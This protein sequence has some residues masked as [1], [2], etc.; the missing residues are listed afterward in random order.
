MDVSNNSC[1][2]CSV[3]CEALTFDLGPLRKLSGTMC[4]HCKV[5]NGCSVYETRWEVCRTYFCG[6]RHL[7]LGEEW[8][9]D[10]AQ[11]LIAF[12]DGLAPDGLSGGIEFT[13]L[14]SHETLLWLPLVKFIAALME[15]PSPVYLSLPGAVGYQSPW[16]YL[17]NIPALQDGI[18]RRDLATTHAALTA[19]LQVCLDYPKTKIP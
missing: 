1:G 3:C 9:P 12:R 15:E 6:W 19:A 13:L 18:A 2:S 5:P 16:V 8:R 4:P 7:G 17:N 10:R 14:G 11:I